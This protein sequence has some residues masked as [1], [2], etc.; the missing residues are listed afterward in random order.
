MNN[1]GEARL[2]QIDPVTFSALNVLDGFLARAPLTRQEHAEAAKNLQHVVQTIEVLQATV[3]E[4]TRQNGAAA[5]GAGE[6]QEAWTVEKEAAKA[7][8]AAV[9]NG[10]RV[11]AEVAEE[12]F[13]KAK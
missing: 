13:R 4:L 2:P 5:N 7:R 11:V 8:G 6:Q 10:T 12:I 1:Q 3:K 9:E